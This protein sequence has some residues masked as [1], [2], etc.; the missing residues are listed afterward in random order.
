MKALEAGEL[1]AQPKTLGYFFNHTVPQLCP[2][3][4]ETDI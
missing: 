3:Q 4:H 2:L 1:C